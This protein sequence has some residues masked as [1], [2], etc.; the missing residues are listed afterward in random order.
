MAHKNIKHATDTRDITFIFIEIKHVS[1]LKEIYGMKWVQKRTREFLQLFLRPP[2]TGWTTLNIHFQIKPLQAKNKPY[3]RKQ[4]EEITKKPLQHNT[5][6][7]RSMAMVNFRGKRIF[8]FHWNNSVWS[9]TVFVP[10]KNQSNTVSMGKWR[11]QNLYE[12]EG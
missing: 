2:R 6:S 4:K 3:Q 8:L 10:R 1:L 9:Y 12:M 5:Y 11:K 7:Y